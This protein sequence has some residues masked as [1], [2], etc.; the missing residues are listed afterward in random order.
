MR[1]RGLLT[2]AVAV[3]LAGAPATATA[4][5][6]APGT[7]LTVPPA[8]LAAALTCS[9]GVDRAAVD[10]VLL[11]PAFSTARESY[12]GGYLDLLPKQG[13]PTCSVTLEDRGFGDLQT[14]TEYAVHAIREVAA[15]SG[16]K[17]RVLGH[18]HGAVDLLLA[19]RFWPDLPALVSDYV[20]LATPHQGTRFAADVCSAATACAPSVHQI[21]RGSALLAAMVRE[22][23]P[24][25]PD[26]TSI[27]T[28]YDEVIT[29]QPQASR[30]AG[31][32]NIT[33]QDVCPR[34]PVEHF[35][36][37]SDALT[38]RLVLDAFTHPGPA[39]PARLLNP[40]V[41]PPQDAGG[42]FGLENLSFVPNFVLLNIT[43]AT[44]DEPALRCPFAAGCPVATVPKPAAG[45]TC[46]SRRR[47]TV[48]VPRGVTRLRAVLN[49]RALRPR[50][51]SVTVDL[52]GRRAGTVTLRLSGRTAGGRAYR[53]VRRY[54]AC[55]T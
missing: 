33:L 55:G 54:R 49:G 9:P 32:R 37:L 23:P 21:A 48:T 35:T 11:V 15:R 5:A 52:R 38:R 51:R 17:V 6:A 47:F 1:C 2:T 34:R 3:L 14:A 13:I 30:M 46:R 50:G 4:T 19:L 28:A 31:A 10:P 12:G 27:A 25:G 18:Q 20:S 44:G 40:C 41:D 39:D 36:I 45:Q 7:P 22:P 29:P 16:R 42:G 26:Y 43:Q 24:A 8:K 53:S